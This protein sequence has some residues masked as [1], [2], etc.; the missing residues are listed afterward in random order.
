MW[1]DPFAQHFI[2]TAA[3]ALALETRQKPQTHEP[4]VPAPR[5]ERRA[6]R[7]TNKMSTRKATR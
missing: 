7:P 4:A 1:F 5:R 3:T 2:M 6:V